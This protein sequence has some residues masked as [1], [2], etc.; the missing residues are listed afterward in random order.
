MLSFNFW[1][2]TFVLLLI[3]RIWLNV[4]PFPLHVGEFKLLVMKFLVLGMRMVRASVVKT[5][6]KDGSFGSESYN[7]IRQLEAS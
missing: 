3:L 7:I 1:N 4:C 6:W 5:N 2:P